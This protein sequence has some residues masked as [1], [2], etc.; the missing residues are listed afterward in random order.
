MHL[1]LMEHTDQQ[2]LA[3]GHRLDTSHV[4]DVQGHGLGSDL[5]RLGVSDSG[6]QRGCRHYGFE[7]VQSVAPLSHMLKRGAAGH[8]FHPRELGAAL[9]HL[10]QGVESP[11]VD[12]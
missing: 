1:R 11:N 2:S 5:L 10:Q 3:P 7:P 6:E 9:M 12:W 8:G 4:H